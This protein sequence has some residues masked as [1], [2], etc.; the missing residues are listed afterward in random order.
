MKEKW[1]IMKCYYIFKGD[2][3]LG[4]DQPVVQEQ[5]IGKLLYIRKENPFY[6]HPMFAQAFGGI[7][8]SFSYSSSILRKYINLK[9]S[10]ILN[11]GVFP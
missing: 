11:N 7:L 5:I 10:N 9:S 8:S 3:N 2:T 6:M 1:W 4:I